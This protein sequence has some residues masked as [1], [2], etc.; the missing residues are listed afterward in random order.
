MPYL[1]DGKTIVSYE[2]EES[3]GGKIEYL[4]KW[5]WGELCSGNISVDPSWGAARIYPGAALMES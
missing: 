4:K 2:D 5:G 1:F 3:L